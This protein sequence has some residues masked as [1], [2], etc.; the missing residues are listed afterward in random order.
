M[1][2]EAVETAAA[3]HFP[4]EISTNLFFL[5]SGQYIFLYK[6]YI[7]YKLGARLVHHRKGRI[8]IIMVAGG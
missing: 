2:A 1:A 7:F 3:T 6:P 4:P 8:G 5:I